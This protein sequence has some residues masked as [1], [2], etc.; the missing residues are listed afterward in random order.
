MDCNSKDALSWIVQILTDKN[1]PYQIVGGLAAR[2]HGVKRQLADIDFD[3]PIEF[4]ADLERHLL[5]YVS[6]PLKRYIEE[7]WD[8]EYFQIIYSGQ[9]VEFGCVPGVKILNK[10]NGIWVD[11]IT[12]FSKSVE[13]H[14]EGKKLQVI[15]VNDL[16]HYKTILDREVDRIDVVELQR[17]NKN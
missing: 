3:I 13:V 4:A 5:P 2:L 14:F 9:K 12:D 10:R 16:I 6:K 1:I 17:I 7:P 15:P 11:L 8:I